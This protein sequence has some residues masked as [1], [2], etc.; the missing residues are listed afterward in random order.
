MRIVAITP[1]LGLLACGGGASGVSAESDVRIKVRLE[2]QDSHLYD[3]ASV[4][5][6]LKRDNVVVHDQLEAASGHVLD[7]PAEVIVKVPIG[8]GE[9]VVDATPH[10][11]DGQVLGGGEGQVTATKDTIAV[12]T[13]GLLSDRNRPTRGRLSDPDGSVDPDAG[14]ADAAPKP[15]AAAGPDGP[16]P[17]VNLAACSPHSYR[18][19][20]IAVASVDYGSEPR[21]R[22]G[23]QVSVSSGFAHD[24]IHAFVGWMRYDL[25][26]VSAGARLV[27]ARLSLVLV[28]PP[29][30]MPELTILY[31]VTDTWQPGVITSETAEQVERTAQVA[32]SLGPPKPA[33]ADYPLDADKYRPYFARDLV[34]HAVTLGMFSLTPP[35]QPE[36][37]ADFYGLD[38]TQLAPVLELDTCE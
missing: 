13:V 16:S 1:L 22:E 6:D 4:D 18:L 14:A 38:P 29:V 24:H 32:G 3:V 30:N 19:A 31:S 15:D 33:R 7:F 37:W 11:L 10:G 34:D 5:L 9:L 35:M 25:S 12:V 8:A 2:N 28:R 17:D 21:D 26:S 23:V 27:G 20:A 36:A